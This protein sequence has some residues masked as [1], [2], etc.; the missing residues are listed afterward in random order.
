MPPQPGAV[1]RDIP[2]RKDRC[3]ATETAAATSPD[4]SAIAYESEAKEGDDADLSTGLP[5]ALAVAIISS[6]ALLRILVGYGH[7]SGEGGHHGKSDGVSYGGDY[8][9]QRHWMELTTQLPL[10]EWYSREPEYWGLDYPPLTAYHSYLCGVLSAVLVGPHTVALYDS[11]G[12][13]E[14][15]H[16][17]FMRATALASD[18]VVYFTAVWALS[19]RLGAVGKGGKDG[20]GGPGRSSAAGGNRRAWILTCALCH[21]ASVLIDHGHFQYNSVSLGLALWSFHLMTSGPFRNCVAG[22]VVFSLGLNFKQMN[23]YYAPTVFA[24]LLGR[25]RRGGA[26]RLFALRFCALGAA[27]VLTF[28]ALWA[29]LV[30]Y[31]LPED[32][33]AGSLLRILRRLFP[34]QRGL[35]E[36]KV[37]NLWCALSV[38]PFSVRQRIP[39]TLQA[40]LATFLTLFL[41]MPPCVA[42]FHAGSDGSVEEARVK[43]MGFSG[44]ERAR[45]RHL[46]Y[47]LWGAAGTALSFFLCSFQVHEK[48]ILLA[49]APVSILAADD[50]LF[51]VWF[52]LSAAWSLWPLLVVDRLQLAYTA[53]AAVFCSLAYLHGGP[54]EEMR[55]CRGGEWRTPGPSRSMWMWTA[56]SAT[57]FGMIALHFLEIFGP[58][59]PSS[60]PDLFPVLWSVFGCGMFFL[61]WMYCC[62]TMYM[63][64]PLEACRMKVD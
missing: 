52:V 11:R 5:P 47:I 19:A 16:K 36:G 56:V 55:R 7:H 12:I 6:A 17:S 60:L 33:V 48:S 41:V 30:I 35:F 3:A 22:A 25:C 8:E 20:G 62:G 31:R 40:P 21:P 23:L 1:R 37:A 29:P 38:R 10:G 15:V 50:Q 32:A 53:C 9:A 44:A 42:L 18:L 13:E 51:A 34:F 64:L 45:R 54:T 2:D 61:S 26:S 49:A 27:V 24:Y 58:P 59:P 43:G 4:D 39:S 14:P 28:V 63:L 46:R 57:V